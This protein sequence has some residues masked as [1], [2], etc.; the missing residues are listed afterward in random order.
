MTTL[1]A[2]VAL[3]LDVANGHVPIVLLVLLVVLTVANLIMAT[4][5]SV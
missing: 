2:S 3:V 1:V 5:R 4:S